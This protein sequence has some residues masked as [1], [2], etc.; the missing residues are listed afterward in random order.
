MRLWLLIL[1]LATVSGSGIAAP[2][3]SFET[4]EEISGRNREIIE[5]AFSHAA[6]IARELPPARG[7]P[8]R[9]RSKRRVHFVLT[10]STNAMAVKY[11]RTDVYGADAFSL[12]DCEVEKE[13]ELVTYVFLLVDR[14]VWDEKPEQRADGF[15]RMI[16]AIGHELY[17]NVPAHLK[18]RPG[19]TFDNSYETKQ[20]DEVVAHKAGVAFLN[21]L[22]ASDH[23]KGLG[24]AHLQSALSRET[25]GLKAWEEGT[26]C[27]GPL[28]HASRGPEVFVFGGGSMFRMRFGRRN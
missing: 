28:A 11:G 8:L 1:A 2:E 5:E 9:S 18:Y 7:N 15:V 24:L 27:G 19:Q 4:T 22:M 20:K 21:R 26:A 13:D 12:T 16:A 17:G 10:N 6:G 14:I 25:E 3:F 23:A